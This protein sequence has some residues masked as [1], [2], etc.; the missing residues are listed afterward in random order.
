MVD[1]GRWV[2]APRYD[3]NTFFRVK[4]QGPKTECFA[5]SVISIVESLYKIIYGNNITIELEEILYYHPHNFSNGG[6]SSFCL[7]YLMTHGLRSKRPKNKIITIDGFV[8]I[9]SFN[10][11]YLLVAVAYQSVTAHMKVGQIFQN[12]K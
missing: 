9:P 3:C 1:G 2:L 11:G 6:L 4:D 12:W 10:E 8:R 5:I 7:G